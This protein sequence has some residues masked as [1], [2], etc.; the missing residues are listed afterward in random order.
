[1]DSG[2]PVVK[3][4]TWIA[5][6][7]PAGQGAL[8]T[9][10]VVGPNAWDTVRQIF[11][12]RNG[13]LPITPQP[14]RF[15]LGRLG[16]DLH[17]DAVLAVTR[18][19][20]MCCLELHVHGGREVVHYLHELFLARGV[21][22]C[23]WPDFLR[24]TSA[25]PLQALAAAALAEAPTARTAAILLDQYHGAFHQA[26]QTI[27]S[28]LERR[29]MTAALGVGEELARSA[30][31]GRHLTTPWRVVIAGAPNVGKSSLLNALTGYQRSIVAP[32]P[33]TTRDVVTV[34]LAIDGWPVEF[35]D[36]AGMREAAD[37]L[38]GQGIEQAR[39]T[40]ATADLCLWVLEATAPPVWPE[41]LSAAVRLVLNKTD[42]P[43]H[44]E[45]SAACDAARLSAHTGAGI[46]ELCALLGRWL[47]PH[48]PPPGAAIPF[49][50]SLC[51]GILETYQLLQNN[52]HVGAAKTLAALRRGNF[53]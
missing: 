1:M 35:V 11:Q 18:I 3:A 6:L 38:E 44:W 31:L 14:G 8:A 9:L 33:G 37:S 16:G 26:L 13:E 5:C 42:L 52:N 24:L 39:A 28:H 34:R 27:E 40:T 43:A 53:T 19:E 2:N 51:V 45:V 36:T 21:E 10:A 32:T 47:V 41:A 46:A 30:P 49:T 17:D 15:W 4:T 23:S 22:S 29:D 12:P 48:V 25:D 7:T 20:P 50:P